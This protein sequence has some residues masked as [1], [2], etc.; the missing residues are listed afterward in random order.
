MCVCVCVRVCVCVSAC[1]R[2]CVCVHIHMSTSSH[3]C[4]VLD[5]WEQC[6]PKRIRQYIHDTVQKGGTVDS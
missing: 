4:A 1:A 6:S 5:F 3:F 2:V